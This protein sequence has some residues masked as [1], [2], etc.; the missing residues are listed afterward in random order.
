MPFTQTDRLLR[1]DTPLGPDVLLLREFTG[2]EAVS[3]LFKYDLDLLTEGPFIQYEDIIGQPVTVRI[4]LS[5]EEE[6]VF[7]GFISRFAQTGSESGILHYRAEMVPWL[8]FLTRTA[9]CRIFQNQTVPDII[10]QI[11]QDLGFTDYQISLEGTYEPLEYCVQYRETDFNFVTRLMEQYGIFY[12]FEHEEETHTLVL[13]DAITVNQPLPI[14]SQVAW[15][16]QGSG[17]L[18]EDV[19]TGLEFEK[20]LMPGKFAHTD[21]NFKAPSTNIAADSPSLVDIG[22]NQQYEIFDF[23]GEYWTKAQG[24]TLARIRME[25][26]EAQ[27]FL[28]T[29]SS[30]CRE[31]ASGYRFNLV[32]Y[33]PTELNQAYVLTSVS[34]MA[35]MGNTYSPGGGTA[36][37]Q[38]SYNNSFRCIPHSVLFRPP[39][40]TPKPMV[41]GAQTAKVVGKPGEEIWTDEFGRVKVLFHWDREGREKE[42]DTCSCWIRVSQVHAGKGFG[43]VDIPRVG[44]EVIIGFLEGDPDQPIIIGRVYN[45]DNMPP[46]GL[47]TAGMTSGLKSNSTPGGGGNNCMMMDDTKGQEGI[48]IHGQ[49]DMSTT[50]ENDLSATVVGGNETHT[51]SA[52]TQTVTIQG[53]ASLT[54]NAG[55]RIVDVTGSYKCDTTSEINLQAPTK[56]TLTCGGSTITMEPGKITMIAGGGAS[57]TL[58]ADALMVSSGGS[59]ALLDANVTV[60]SSGGSTVLL[61]GNA[62]MSGAA[63]ATVEA[64]S[65]STLSGGGATVV[66]DASGVAITGPKISLN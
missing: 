16:P 5:G 61:D 37:G 64:A 13:G 59:Q 10:E 58:D 35:S 25:T 57:L 2:H 1:I 36:A 21:Y 32:D 14:Q 30:T 46:N 47:P 44:E 56:I 40:M 38:E 20:V 49:K 28:I 55:D 65:K 4:E 42:D 27:H 15:E 3:Q 8:W 12:F 7:H 60:Q 48:T 9:D 29:G 26:E 51:V 17:M 66:N 18:D 62:T 11:F 6:R 52:G 22:G 33:E 24:D 31:F 63:E 54:V 23:P 45:Q 41:Q 39:R 34:H 53:N 50:V 19:I 43:G